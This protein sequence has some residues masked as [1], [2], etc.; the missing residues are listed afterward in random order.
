MAILAREK[1]K[2][3]LG[4][5]TI[6]RRITHGEE[7]IILT[8]EEYERRV[9]QTGEILRTLKIIAQGEKELKEGKTIIAASLKEALKT[10]AEARH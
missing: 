9:R 7:L 4:I 8:R 5:I 6:P 10:Y 2:K 3:E 1:A